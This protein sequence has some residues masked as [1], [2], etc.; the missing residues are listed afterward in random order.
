MS[1]GSKICPFDPPAFFF[2]FFDDE[3]EEDFPFVPVRD[4]EGEALRVVF[5]DFFAMR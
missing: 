3:R 5:V 2:F 4:A 1:K